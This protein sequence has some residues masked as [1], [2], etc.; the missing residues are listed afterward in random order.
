MRFL[1]VAGAFVVV[2]LAGDDARAEPSGQ[3]VA[4]SQALFDEGKRLMQA[5]SFAEACPKLAESQRLDPAGGT[6]LALGFCHE[7]EGKTATAWADFNQAATEARRDRRPDREAVALEHVHALEARLTKVRILT[8][9]ASEGLEVRR[10][11]T[12]VG[13]AQWGIPL[14]VDPGAVTFEAYAPRKRRWSVTLTISEEGRTVDVPIPPLE[15]VSPPA[16]RPIEVPTPPPATDRTWA[17][18]AGGT[19]LAFT[20]VG[21]VFGLMATSKWREAK[22]E[23]SNDLGRDAGTLADV[24]TTAFVLGGI[25]L[26]FSAVLFVTAPSSTKPALSGGLR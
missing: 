3:D 18:I 11:G 10:N 1:G 2:M 7:G 13:Q 22:G 5:K 19:G 21:A 8:P 4:L 14:P 16:S 25:A 23:G 9:N 20:G 24:S 6:T 26:A 12:A 15:D 17:W